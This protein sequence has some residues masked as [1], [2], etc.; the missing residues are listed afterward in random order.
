[1]C[2]KE[3]RFANSSKQTKVR[4]CFDYRQLAH[5]C[6]TQDEETFTDLLMQRYEERQKY[7]DYLER[8]GSVLAEKYRSKNAIFSVRNTDAS[9]D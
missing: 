3:R 5:K 7:L 8:E 9:D 1:M 6:Y 4:R 2:R